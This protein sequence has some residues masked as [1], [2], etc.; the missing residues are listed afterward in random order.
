MYNYWNRFAHFRR[1]FSFGLENEQR[2]TYFIYDVHIHSTFEVKIKQWAKCNVR[3]KRGK[4]NYKFGEKKGTVK[5]LNILNH[6]SSVLN[7]ALSSSAI[8]VSMTSSSWVSFSK[9]ARIDFD[10]SASICE[11][12]FAGKVGSSASSK[13]GDGGEGAF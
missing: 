9:S 8:W 3:K 4:L 13:L 5:L 7:L 6:S 10:M 12:P 1:Y 2:R 11:E